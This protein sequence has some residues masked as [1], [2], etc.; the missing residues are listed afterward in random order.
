MACALLPG[1]RPVW[2]GRPSWRLVLEEGLELLLEFVEIALSLGADA[3]DQFLVRK[4]PAFG[5]Q[6]LVVRVGY[7]P[8]VLL[9]SEDVRRSRLLFQAPCRVEAPPDDIPTRDTLLDIEAVLHFFC[10]MGS[11]TLAY[12]PRDNRGSSPAN[13]HKRNFIFA[14]N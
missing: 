11:G 12:C 7:V 5:S 8:G 14:G 13:S 4:E 3:L 9:V 1:L 6:F 10:S 2:L